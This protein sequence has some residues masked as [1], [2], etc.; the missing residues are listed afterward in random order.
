VV[1]KGE[2]RTGRVLPSQESVKSFLFSS[3]HIMIEVSHVA[4]GGLSY[5]GGLKRLPPQLQ[6][7]GVPQNTI[8]RERRVFTLS[9]HKV[10]NKV[11]LMISQT[12]QA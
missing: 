3:F 10:K 6:N 5:D 1:P 11:I 4:R 9:K 12:T 8:K 7:E 2:K